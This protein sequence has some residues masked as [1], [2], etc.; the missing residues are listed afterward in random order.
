MRYILRREGPYF[1]IENPCQTTV[2][3]NL[4]EKSENCETFRDVLWICGRPVL[5]VQIAGDV[6]QVHLHWE[7]KWNWDEFIDIVCCKL[8]GRGFKSYLLPSTVCS[9]PVCELLAQ[10]QW[11][12]SKVYLP[13]PPPW[14]K[15][16]PLMYNC[17]RELMKK[18]SLQ[19]SLIKVNQSKGD[20]N[21]HFQDFPEQSQH[22]AL[23]FLKTAPLFQ[24]PAKYIVW[25]LS[26]IVFW[27]DL[28]TC[29]MVYYFR[30]IRCSPP[31]HNQKLAMGQ[32]L[33]CPPCV[34]L[35]TL[36]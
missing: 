6:H 32:D 19:R 4:K 10:C 20:Q 22:Y 25:Y 17:N 8:G 11:N 12:W 2:I 7:T 26:T 13:S 15:A 35:R 9:E 36:D 1:Q 14:C 21:I 34:H 27:G 33:I 23:C 30:W 16:P 5:L 28:N 24:N 18:K 3:T 31:H 29:F